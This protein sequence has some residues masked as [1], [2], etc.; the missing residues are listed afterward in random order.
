MNER[1]AASVLRTRRNGK[2]LVYDALGACFHL[3]SL[4]PED[5][6]RLEAVHERVLDWFGHELRWTWGSPL[7]RQQ[8]FAREHLDFVTVQPTRLKTPVSPSSSPAAL[9]EMRGMALGLDAFNVLAHGGA[10]SS[11]ASPYNYQFYSVVAMPTERTG[12]FFDT[13]TMVVVTVPRSWP[14]SDFRER[15]LAIAAELR[16]RWAV[17]GLTYGSWPHAD[18]MA[19]MQAIHGH[20][21]RFIGYDTCQYAAHLA[22]AWHDSLRTVSWM[23]LLG[24]AFARASSRAKGSPR[25]IH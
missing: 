4:L 8:P 20:A 10:A 17:A 6:Q 11:D 23:T 12:E 1:P 16:V 5:E 14:L 9:T 7:L 15:V 25:Q 2:P 19:T 13:R 24:E 18:Y 22:D 21:S 3:E